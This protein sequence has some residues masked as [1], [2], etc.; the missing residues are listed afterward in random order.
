MV[1]KLDQWWETVKHQKWPISNR[2][3]RRPVTIDASPSE[4]IFQAIWNQNQ[5]V[6]LAR[7]LVLVCCD[8][9]CRYLS[10]TTWMCSKIQSK[11]Q[12]P[13]SIL[14]YMVQ[15]RTQDGTINLRITLISC[16]VLFTQI[17][18]LFYLLKHLFGRIEKKHKY[19]LGFVLFSSSPTIVAVRPF[20]QIWL[21]YERRIFEKA[22]WSIWGQSAFF[23]A[24]LEKPNEGFSFRF[25]GKFMRDFC[26]HFLKNIF[27]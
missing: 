20:H 9:F 19:K 10:L 26:P 25:F 2:S 15:E 23:V 1:A 16:V 4:K 6:I 11:I 13:I 21:K 24:L 3:I 5:P 12:S 8:Y 14:H 17:S 7:L 22:S 18:C 27:V